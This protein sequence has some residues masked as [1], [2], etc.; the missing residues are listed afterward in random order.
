MASRLS[1]LRISK[2]KSPGTTCRFFEL[3]SFLGVDALNDVPK[4]DQ[5]SLILKEKQDGRYFFTV[6]THWRQRW[7]LHLGRTKRKAGSCPY[8][9]GEMP[10]AG[11]VGS[12]RK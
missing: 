6:V 10:G 1:A 9:L 11:Q 5:Q 12:L 8:R 3:F 2:L 4:P 7:V